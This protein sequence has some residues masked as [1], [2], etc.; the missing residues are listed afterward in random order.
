MR[1]S[2]K[3]KIE[4]GI[5]TC[6]QPKLAHYQYA[7]CEFSGGDEPFKLGRFITRLNI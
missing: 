7:M 3:K 1:G 6:L 5:S 2:V 4:A